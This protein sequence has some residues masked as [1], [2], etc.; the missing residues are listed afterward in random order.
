MRTPDDNDNDDD[1]DVVV[2]VEVEVEWADGLRSR[3]GGWDS[4]GG[5]L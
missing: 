4:R 3:E 2:V 5:S 1:D